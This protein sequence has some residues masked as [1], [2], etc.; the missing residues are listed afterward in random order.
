MACWPHGEVE[1]CK[2][3]HASHQFLQALRTIVTLTMTMTIELMVLASI[4]SGLR[5]RSDEPKPK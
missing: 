4:V 5:K 3:I 1:R 2:G